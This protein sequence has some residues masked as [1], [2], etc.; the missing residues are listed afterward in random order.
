V[1]GRW[2]VTVRS[3]APVVRA[4]A[5]A[6]ALAGL[7]LASTARADDAQPGAGGRPFTGT[8]AH[9]AV[10]GW[11][12]VHVHITADQRAG[13]RVISGEPFVPAGIEQALGQD[14]SEHGADGSLDATG[15]L[16]RDGLPFGTHD[17]HGWP[18]VRPQRRRRR[19]LRAVRGPL[20]RHALQQEG[21]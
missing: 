5:V 14:A 7:A 12:D 16:L 1:P 2:P 9:G 11:A 3:D 20:G 6:G 4:S 17:T 15:N 21:R 18:D 13:G 8:D 10:R 19:P